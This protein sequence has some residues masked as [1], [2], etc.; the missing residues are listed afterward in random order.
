MSLLRIEKVRKAFDDLVVLDEIS[1]EVPDK[2]VTALIGAS[3]S[4][5]S[6]LLRAI[7][8]LEL[9][10]DGQI[11][12]DGQDITEVETD[13]DL[14]R[15]KLGM[16]FQS[17]NLFPHKTVLENITLAPMLVHG[18]GK[19]QA[20]SEAHDL[21]KKFGLLEKVDQYPDRLSGGQQQRVAIIR[22]MA[23]KPKLLLLDEITSALDP[24][25][26]NEVLETVRELKNDGV[27]IVMATHEMGFAKQIA[28]QVCFL[29][30]GRILERGDASL[31][32]SPKEAQT[33]E[34]LL[35]VQQ[36]GRL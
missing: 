33:Q 6:T 4:G 32:T 17:F 36:A 29:Y 35:R 3:G 34:F 5:K 24:V 12:F 10:D 16:V 7:N 30:Q 23:V 25:L 9:V 13:V 14:V 27:A 21:L 8:L 28:D 22:A 31:L 11:F 1:F 15:R 18:I 20:E 2:T 26:V 19:E